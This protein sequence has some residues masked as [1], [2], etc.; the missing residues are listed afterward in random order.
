MQCGMVVLPHTVFIGQELYLIIVMECHGQ[1]TE[2]S[3]RS[4]D[5]A[6]ILCKLAMAQR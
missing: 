6:L 3:S 5:P 2:S 4:G 1:N